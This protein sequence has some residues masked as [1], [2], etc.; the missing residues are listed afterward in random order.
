LIDGEIF[1][2]QYTIVNIGER[3]AIP[4]HHE[5]MWYVQPASDE[6]SV[7]TE[8]RSLPCPE[9]KPGQSV[10]HN[11]HITDFSRSFDLF[12]GGEFKIRGAIKYED[13]AGIVRRTGFLRTYNVALK[14]FRASEDSGEEYED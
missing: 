6:T 1:T 12:A 4:K 14:C 3:L 10:S 8:G 2:I 7:I 11:I 13:D 9:L 5:I